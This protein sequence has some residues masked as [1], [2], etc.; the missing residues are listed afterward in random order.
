MTAGFRE[1]GADEA[2]RQLDFAPVRAIPFRMAIHTASRTLSFDERLAAEA[3]FSGRP[4]NPKW[5]Q[6]ARVVYDGILRAL[7]TTPA[8]D[9]GLALMESEP[10]SADA[11]S[12][13]GAA[14]E[15]VHLMVTRPP[16]DAS[17]AP[18]SE[19]D[20]AAS[21]EDDTTLSREQAIEAGG[22][23]EVTPLAKRLGVPYSV[24]MTRPAW[25]AVVTAS[26]SIPEAAHEGRVRDILLA[27]RL[28]LMS[29]PVN[30]SVIDFPAL[31]TFPPDSVPQP[32]LLL[33]AFHD[34][35]QAPACIT[36]LLPRE[37][38]LLL[39]DRRAP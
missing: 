6:A 10:G 26:R 12:A 38:S 28:R 3:A 15:P 22:L 37:L 23:I 14:Q 5:S 25:E 19:H 36:L 9:D 35:P 16:A 20:L 1:I 33:A 31:L 18:D 4:F 24:G 30:R 11:L 17:A 39:N 34:S 13:V 21:S 27:L 2:V 32:Q 29:G 7:G 8:V